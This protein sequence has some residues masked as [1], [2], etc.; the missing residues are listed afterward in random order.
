MAQAAGTTVEMTTS[1]I[2][3]ILSKRAVNATDEPA[4]GSIG[5]I[6][7]KQLQA[8]D[9]FR[10]ALIEL[11]QKFG[12]VYIFIDELNRCKGNPKM[13]ILWALIR[14]L[15]ID[16]NAVFYPEKD[17]ENSDM[18]RLQLLLEDCS[19]EEVSMLLSICESVLEAFRSAQGKMIVDQ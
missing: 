14:V 18:K 12:G 4:E 17:H 15:G 13:E 6:Y 9:A 10:D 11:S 5:D 19:D 3:D 2:M 7:D 8:R 16:A 1:G